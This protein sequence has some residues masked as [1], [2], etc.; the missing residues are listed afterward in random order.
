MDDKPT[1]PG[2]GSEHPQVTLPN[3]VVTS[4][5]GKETEG[6]GNGN[7][8]DGGSSS[9]ESTFKASLD[10]RRRVYG[11]NALPPARSKTLLELMWLALKDK[12]LVRLFPTSVALRDSSDVFCCC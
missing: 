8:N 6:N 12:V 3:I 4:P 7:G 10:N 1:I 5:S 2:E 9:D 11:E